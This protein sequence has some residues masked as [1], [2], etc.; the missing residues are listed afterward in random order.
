MMPPDNGRAELDAFAA[1]MREQIGALARGL[2][3]RRQSARRWS[4]LR[5]GLVCSWQLE[6]RPSRP[7]LGARA[8]WGFPWTTSGSG[9]VPRRP[10]S[11]VDLPFGTSLLGGDGGWW[12]PD[13]ANWS[14]FADEFRRQIVYLT[15]ILSLDAFL[16]IDPLRTDPWPSSRPILSF[17]PGQCCD[18][19]E[20]V[21]AAGH[22]GLATKWLR[23]AQSGSTKDESFWKSAQRLIDAA[24]TA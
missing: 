9:A 17:V 24:E 11:A 18:L 4:G 14:E 19:G 5:G 8:R 21:L 16:A 10:R 15:E 13:S 12:A 1:A 3:L 2:G 20:L 23:R 22:R 6:R 7:G